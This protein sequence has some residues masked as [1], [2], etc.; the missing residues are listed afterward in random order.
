MSRFINPPLQSLGQLPAT[1]RSLIETLDSVLPQ[2]CDFYIHPFLNGLTF[3]LVLLHPQLGV[4]IIDVPSASSDISRV[5]FRQNLACEEIRELYCPRRDTRAGVVPVKTTIF[6][7]SEIRSEWN[8]SL[9]ECSKDIRSDIRRRIV[10]EEIVRQEPMQAILPLPGVPAEDDRLY[11]DLKSWLLEPDFRGI[12][13]EPLELDEK[14]R[15]LST[16]RTVGGYRRIKGPAGSGKTHVLA[17]RAAQTAAEGKTVLFVSFNLTLI[18]FVREA[19]LR[20]S[21]F[22]SPARSKRP[23][24]R[25][26]FLN[27]HAWAKRLFDLAGKKTDYNRLWADA[28]D[29]KDAKQMVL[30]RDLAKAVSKLL[31]DLVDPDEYDVIIVDEGQDFIPE[32]LKNLRQ[33]LRQK[34]EFVLAVD[35]TQDLYD[36]ERLL[37]PGAWEG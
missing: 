21:L 14:Q 4:S 26:T 29:D 23:M 15:V 37:T 27:Y 3:T 9:R 36:R 32:W 24:D 8:K 33:V 18:N 10:D 6:I 2:E 19:A 34:G 31:A 20:W 16:T 28:G 1:E 12:R 5:F 25:I 13:R 7:P 11:R 30:E 17:A 22:D 35:L